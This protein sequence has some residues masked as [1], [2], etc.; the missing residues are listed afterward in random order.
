MPPRG[1]SLFGV[2]G[3]GDRT[4]SL[5]PFVAA[6]CLGLGVLSLALPSAP[7][8]D[9]WSWIVWG[10]EVMGGNLD[11]TGA[12]S[13]KPLPVL[14]TAPFS[15]FGDLAPDL[16]LVVAR[17]AGFGAIAAAAFVGFRLA[18]RVGAVLSAVVLATGAWFWDPTLRGGSEGALALC[19]LAGVDRHLAGSRAQAFAWWVAAALIRPEVWLFLGLYAA[20]LVV[21]RPPRWRWVLPGLVLVPAL[22]LLPEIW[23]SGDLWRGA[24]RAQ[25][26]L[27][28]GSPGLAERPALAVLDRAAALTQAV[29]DLGLVAGVATVLLR[30]APRRA[31]APA[32][33][34]A[35]FGVALL[36]IVA[37]MSEMGFSG[38][39]RYLLM[40]VTVASVLG[41]VGL[42]W[43][44]GAL[45]AGGA[46]G[47]GATALTACLAGLAL[48][49]ALRSIHFDWP[50]LIDVVQRDGAVHRDLD[51]AV[52]RAGGERQLD[53]C[54]ALYAS[55]LLT[56]MVAWTF[57]R[58]LRE[59]QAVPRGAGVL[60]R[61]RPPGQGLRPVGTSLHDGRTWRVLSRSR[62]WQIETTC[63]R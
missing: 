30:K 6:G 32:L 26:H 22:W 59:V 25:Q 20:W 63:T 27:S 45:G 44:I 12:V 46:R 52:A 37:V 58:H 38:N 28:E 36:V 8:Y 7:S 47:T 55:N 18:G 9:P 41:G 13:W 39:D 2:T 10:R 17:T 48:V 42:A 54:G 16:W 1:A 60:L 24:D 3:R 61:E 11:T 51:V 34:L 50:P 5:V 56:P 49:L 40:S 57:H 21:D 19:V 31:L 35:A 53:E 4:S 43:A 15:L 14:F 33:G 62:H 29:A 23:G